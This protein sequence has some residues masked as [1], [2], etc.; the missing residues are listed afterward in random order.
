M[1]SFYGVFRCFNGSIQCFT[2]TGSSVYLWTNDINGKSFQMHSS[3]SIS[4]FLKVS[5]RQVCANHNSIRVV[6]YVG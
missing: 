5:L 6:N 4:Y 1:G 2:F 3:E